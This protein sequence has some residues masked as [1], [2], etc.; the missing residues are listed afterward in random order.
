VVS[1][2]FEARA[3]IRIILPVVWWIGPGSWSLE[4]TNILL[5]I[6]FIWLG[7]GATYAFARRYLTA[8]GA[9]GFVVLAGFWLRVKTCGAG[10]LPTD[11]E[12]G[13]QETESPTW[14]RIDGFLQAAG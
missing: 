7:L 14:R 6:I 11:P 1:P 8:A 9:F 3:L 2:L 12:D 13:V 5:Q 4:D 10:L